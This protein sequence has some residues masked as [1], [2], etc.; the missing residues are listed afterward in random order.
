[1][2]SNGLYK[3]VFSLKKLISMLILLCMLVT[4][5]VVPAGAYTS[6]IAH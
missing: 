2:L 4:M 3:K 6:E 1:M 5:T